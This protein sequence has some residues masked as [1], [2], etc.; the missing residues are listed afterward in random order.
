MQVLAQ[1]L[2]PIDRIE[3]GVMR[4]VMASIETIELPPINAGWIAL[5]VIGLFVAVGLIGFATWA[6]NRDNE[7]GNGGQRSSNS[8]GPRRERFRSWLSEYEPE[9]EAKFF[10]IMPDGREGVVYR[11]GKIRHRTI[12]RG[13][14]LRLPLINKIMVKSVQDEVIDVPEA[15]IPI[16][17]GTVVGVKSSLLVRITDARKATLLPH[18][19]KAAAREIALRVLIVVLGGQPLAK[20]LAKDNSFDGALTERLTAKLEP[21]GLTVVLFRPVGF[22]L[23]PSLQQAV[24]QVIQA[25]LD[26]QADIANADREVDVATRLLKAA[27]QY[28]DASNEKLSIGEVALELRKFG[29]YKDMRGASVLVSEKKG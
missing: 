13:I 16:E 11:L 21:Y 14:Y 18:D 17:D 26:A 6:R 22:S 15:L 5:L 4:K 27:A 25:R 19:Y 2:V 29:T 1:R 12:K 20:V 23:S 24:E 10:G 3:R 9:S 8:R 28:A 7:D